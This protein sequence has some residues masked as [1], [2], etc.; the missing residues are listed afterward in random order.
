M[1]QEV[2]AEV[3]KYFSTIGK[4]GAEARNNLP[5]EVKSFI[6]LKAW[7]TRRKKGVAKVVLQEH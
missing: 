2:S 4:K 7:K 5:K 1:K 3:T 6:A